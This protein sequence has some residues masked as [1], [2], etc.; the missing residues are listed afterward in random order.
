MGIFRL[1]SFISRNGFIPSTYTSY[2]TTTVVQTVRSFTLLDGTSIPWI[3]W[4]NGTG[5]AQKN[6][7]ECGNLALESGI[8]HIDT[9]QIYYNERETGEAIQR[10]SLSRDDVYVTS[11]RES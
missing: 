3:G 9:A 1:M 11:K 10:S 2:S 7:V 8:R 6:A 5:Q 4:G